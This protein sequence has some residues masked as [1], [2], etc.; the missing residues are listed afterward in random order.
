MSVSFTVH[1]PV[2]L[3]APLNPGKV[4]PLAGA[5]LNVTVVPSMKFA[6]QLLPQSMPVG[7]LATRPVPPPAEVTAIW[8]CPGGGPV[9][10]NPTQPDISMTAAVANIARHTLDAVRMNNDTPYRRHWMNLQQ[11]WLVDL[12]AENKRVAGP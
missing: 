3:H 5:A 9:G 1:P 10:T 6:V 7:A 2:P 11:N 4:N 8:N 12:A